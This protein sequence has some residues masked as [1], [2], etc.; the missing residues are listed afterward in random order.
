MDPYEEL[1]K[2]I[3]TTMPEALVVNSKYVPKLDFASRC[4][5]YA[6]YKAGLQKRVIALAFGINPATMGYIIRPNSPH[7]RDV[8]RTYQEMGHEKFL[9]QY[10]TPE[11]M[12]RLNEAAKNP[13]LKLSIDELRSVNSAA[14][15]VANPKADKSKGRHVFED[16]TGT[17]YYIEVCWVDEPG[18]EPLTGAPRSAG[19]YIRITDDSPTPDTLPDRP[20]YGSDEHSKTSTACVNGLLKT[21]E[22]KLID[23]IYR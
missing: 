18:L 2:Q 17:I 22:G 13:E 14:A 21:M 12:E 9:L 16:G 23:Q 6:A 5:A 7:Y 4:A 20:W 8:R 1:M 19:W 10:L 3:Q 11:I 15:N